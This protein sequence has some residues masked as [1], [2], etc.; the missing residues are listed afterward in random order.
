MQKDKIKISDHFSYNRLLRFTVPSIIMMIFTSIYGVVD[1]LFVSNFTGKT[2]FA[3]INFIIPYTMILSAAGF[4]LGT[5]GN[6][7]ISKLLGEEKKNESKSVFSLIVFVTVISGIILTVIGEIF[8]RPV[9]VILGAQGQL[10]EDAVFYGRIVLCGTTLYMLQSEFQSLF[11]TDGKPK[12]GLTV[13]ILSGLSNIIL[14]WL[15]VGILKYGLTG[16]AVAT[17]ISMSVG[18]ILPIF[19]FVFNKGDDLRFVKFKFDGRALIR[20]CSNG[21]SE[22]V[23]NISMSTVSMLFN[24]QLLK[25]SGED[26]V[27]A[28]GVLMYV[29][30]VFLSAFI[31][32]SL[33]SAPITG[34]NY[35]AKNIPELKN[36]FKKSM[37]LIICFS[38]F[39]VAFSY[40]MSVPFSKIFTGYDDQLY[41]VTL[42]GFMIYSLS[43]L[44]AGI[45]IYS[46]SFF[47]ALNNGLVSAIIS[48]L[49]MFV[50]Q[51]AAVL[52]LPV[53]FGIYGVWWSIVT[54]E[55][56]AAAVSVIFLA[57][58]RKKYHY[59]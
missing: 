26:G 44:F 37:T 16:A 35:G 2:S 18:G 6:A 47:T 24:A 31:G 11:S 42:D 57:A 15:L 29:G 3:A 41:Q 39:M 27:A 7:Y 59:I 13:T 43:F 8:L 25:I 20:I 48:F 34:F 23:T 55:F 9:A 32:Y 21:M 51:V 50:F 52:T 12:L 5:G 54:A 56:L 14:D 30:F 46:S 22:M 53:F 33:G 40:L 45:A 1:G 4:M 38:V 19:Y 17:V 49:R 36:I 28:Y 58:N 10:L